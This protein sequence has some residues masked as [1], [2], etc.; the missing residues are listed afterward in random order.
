MKIIIVADSCKFELPQKMF[1]NS[2]YSRNAFSNHFKKK[3]LIPEVLIRWFSTS[4][5]F[6]WAPPKFTLNEAPNIPSFS[7]YPENS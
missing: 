2:F 1:L 5:Y 3:H 7:P 6:F 4:I